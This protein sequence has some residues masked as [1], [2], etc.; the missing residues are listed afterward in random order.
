[1][2]T[3][4]KLSLA[5]ADRERVTLLGIVVVA[6]F[7]GAY[8]FLFAPGCRHLSDLTAR[9]RE[10]KAKVVQGREMVNDAQRIRRMSAEAVGRLDKSREWIPDETDSGWVLRLIGDVAKTQKVRTAGIQPQKEEHTGEEESGFYR[11]ATCQIQLKTD[12][13]SLGRFVDALE[14]M[15]PYYQFRDL[16]IE[17]SFDDPTRH[18]IVLKLQYLYAQQEKASPATALAS[19]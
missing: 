6:L 19:K 7:V 2:I 5:K 11:E 16:S 18:E 8:F 3:L 12:Y 14:K 13:H 15:S 17:S 10:T 1:M 9:L 4:P